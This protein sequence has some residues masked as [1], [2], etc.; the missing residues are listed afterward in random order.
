MAG[1][2]REQGRTVTSRALAV[3]EAFDTTHV[4]LS[5]SDIARRSDLPL[6][7]AYR[8]VKELET[9]EALVRRPDGL[10]EIGAK[11]WTLGLLSPIF[12]DLRD[13]AFPYMQDVY[14]LCRETVQLAVRD[15]LDALY[16]E[17]IYGRKSV[18]LLNRS[19]TRLPLHATGVGKVLLAHAP[20]PV[21][22]RAV[23]QLSRIT[24]YTVTHPG[25]LSQELAQIH[26]R[27]YATTTEE[28]Q[29]GTCSLAVPVRD[30]AGIVV[31]GLG[32]V[33]RSSRRDLIRLL[34]A[35]QAAAAG[36]GSHLNAS[37]LPASMLG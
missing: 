3:L 36:I 9:W 2:S 1:R 16:V 23:H 14:E 35:L 30:S 29:L 4:R 22:Q 18:P 32:I 8:L 26:T 10:Y 24:P 27:G 13:Q 28:M 33:A 21:I 34:P 37:V 15:D 11:L 5:L 6:A 25:R 31:A 19:G 20:R 7:T 12:G 17:K